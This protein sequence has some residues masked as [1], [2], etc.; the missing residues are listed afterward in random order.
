MV[1]G[2]RPILLEILGQPAPAGAKT[3]IFSIRSYTSAVAP[4]KKVQ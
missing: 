2:G 3:P 1:G 4:S